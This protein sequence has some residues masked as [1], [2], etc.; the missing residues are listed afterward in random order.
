MPLLLAENSVIVPCVTR[1]ALLR[2]LGGYDIRQRYDSED[3]EL[4]IR[5]LASGWPIVTIPMHL[6]KYRI[7]HDS[8]YRSMTDLQNQVMREQLMMANRDIVAK[9]AIEICMQLEHQLKQIAYS[10]SWLNL[11]DAQRS[12][13]PTLIRFGLG[14]KLLQYGYRFFQGLL[15]L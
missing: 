13:N 9:F 7:R 11:S 3:W 14:K 1:T 8:L 6:M 4:S 2:E 5:M 10:D 15:K 12:S